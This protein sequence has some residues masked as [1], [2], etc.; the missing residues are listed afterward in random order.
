MDFVHVLM[1]S[2]TQSLSEKV[3]GIFEE[4]ESA[5]EAGLFWS[6]DNN[7]ATDLSW[8]K[9]GYNLETVQIGQHQWLHIKAVK[10]NRLIE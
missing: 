7:F 9:V 5:R 8:H 10:A 3:L 2:S 6:T 1:T 4:V